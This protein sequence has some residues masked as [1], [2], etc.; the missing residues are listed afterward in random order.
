M[1]L[2]DVLEP[3]IVRMP[4]VERPERRVPFKKKL[5]W[6]LGILVLYFTLTNI[7]VF[8]VRVQGNL[9]GQFRSILAGAQGSILHLG[10]GPIVTASIVLQLLDGAE[11]LPIDTQTPR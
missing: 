1:G 10:I 4:T 9:F 8:G 7:T 5:Y 6:T 11:L 2:I 3:A